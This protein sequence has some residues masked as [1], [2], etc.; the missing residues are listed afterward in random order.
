MS[1]LFSRLRTAGIWSFFLN[2]GAA[3]LLF[4]LP[5]WKLPWKALGAF[6]WLGSIFAPGNYH[7]W[8]IIAVVWCIAANF[9]IYWFLIYLVILLINSIQGRSMTGTP[10]SLK[11]HSST[12]NE[13]RLNYIGRA[14]YQ[15]FYRR[16][17][18]NKSDDGKGLAM[19]FL[20]AFIRKI[21]FSSLYITAVLLLLLPSP[22]FAQ[23]DQSMVDTILQSDAV[24]N[25]RVKR[26]RSIKYISHSRSEDGC[27]TEETKFWHDL[28]IKP[29][30]V[31][32]G[33]KSL[34]NEKIALPRYRQISKDEDWGHGKQIVL[35]KKDSGNTWHEIG[36]YSQAYL[37]KLRCLLPIL[38]E[39][40][41]PVQ[42]QK[43]I[44]LLQEPAVICPQVAWK[45]VING[46]NRKLS[47]ADRSS[48]DPG[49][50]EALNDDVL[51]AIENIK[52]PASFDV[53]VQAFPS[54]RS[55]LKYHVLHWMI[56]TGDQRAIPVLVQSLDAEG[57]FTRQTAAYGLASTFPGAPGVTEAFLKKWKTTNKDVHSEA[58]NYLIQRKPD[59]EL[60]KAYQELHVPLDPFFSKAL[61]AF[62]EGPATDAKKYCIQTIQDS[63]IKD[64]PRVQLMHCIGTVLNREEQDQYMPVIAPFLERMADK[65]SGY[66]Y[67]ARQAALSIAH[68]ALSHIFSPL[69]VDRNLPNEERFKIIMAIQAM[70]ENVRA[71]SAGLLLQWLKETAITYGSPNRQL[72][73]LIALVWLGN[74]Q[75]FEQARQF[76]KT[77]PLSAKIMKLAAELRP[78]S[79]ISDEGAFWIDMLN[80]YPELSDWFILRLSYIRED[81]AI[82]VFLKLL[83]DGSRQEI[84]AKALAQ[85]GEPTVSQIKSIFRKAD[86]N[87]YRFLFNALCDSQKESFMPFVREL[88]INR[89]ADNPDIVWGCFEKYGTA[90]DIALLS[91]LDNYWKFGENAS[92]RNALISMRKKFGYDLNGP[93]ENKFH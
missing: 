52:N 31:F 59:E 46:A 35:L 65:R 76:L 15:A 29:F 70:G 51:D 80:K 78:A 9:I 87:E 67:M 86:L 66:S 16:N 26:V 68:P 30:E 58:V 10:F 48:N 17:H 22:S 85:S 21:Y 71:E 32:R 13:G 12:N 18:A 73:P 19:Q 11:A 24:V 69:V 44:R 91:P 50:L 90:D 41:E 8:G 23:T 42:I 82:P 61:K 56:A 74:D 72:A 47:A 75:D 1:K 92:L 27:V 39:E 28:A 5:E 45:S 62:N 37:P 93:I 77:L 2:L 38:E 84:L 43:F 60:Q 49:S 40:Q 54:F 57:T 89:S 36:H 55:H 63:S 4:I 64:F 79:K 83:K 7:A 53:V 34:V 14:D 6:F 88:V 25:A 3:V 81:R 33:N 20:F